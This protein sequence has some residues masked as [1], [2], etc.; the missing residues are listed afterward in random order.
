VLLVEG[1]G[2]LC[3]DRSLKAAQVSADIYEHTV[4]T[5]EWAESIGRYQPNNEADRFDMEYWDLE[6]AKLKVN[7]TAAAAASADMKGKVALITGAGSGIGLETSRYFAAK[8]AHVVLVD[9]EVIPSET[10]A[11]VGPHRSVAVAVQCDVTCA[12]QVQE[13]FTSACLA[14]G[15]VDVVVS[16]AGAAV[17]GPVLDC[18]QMKKSMDLNFW[19]HQYV[20]VAAVKVFQAQRSKGCVLYNASKAALNPGPNF[21]AY[22]VAKSAVLTLMKCFAQEFGHLGVRFNAVNADRV[23]TAL[24]TQKFVQDRAKA[25]KVTPEEYFKCNLLHDEVLVADVAQAFFHLAVSYRTTAAVV[26]VDGGNIAASVR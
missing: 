15:G 8:G 1:V 11:S 26:T 19:S 9:K 23:R 3:V 20:S 10:V 21:G 6:Q 4:N 2:L 24:F 12:S 17:Q 7:S 13:A 22:A 16:N 14:F 5:I 18:Q 25:R